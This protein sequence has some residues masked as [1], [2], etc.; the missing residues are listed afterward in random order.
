[1]FQQGYARQIIFTGG[2]C[3]CTQTNSAQYG[4]ERALQQRV[5]SQ[6][7]AIDGSEVTSTYSEVVRLKELIARSQ[8]SI[9]SVIVVS[10]PY[11]MRRAR[12]TCRRVLGNQILLQMAPVPFEQSSHQHHWWTDA[13]SRNMVRDEYLKTVY[14]YARYQLSWGPVR[15]WLASLDRE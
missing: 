2:W 11:H 4:Q 10:D 1:L 14:Y 6:A 3:P 7:I 13:E 15:D 9:R 12:W 5:P 8:S